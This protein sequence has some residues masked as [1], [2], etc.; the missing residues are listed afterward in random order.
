M[1][2]A[3]AGLLKNALELSKSIYLEEEGNESYGKFV[4]WF[5][6]FGIFMM[7]LY[8]NWYGFYVM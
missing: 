3:M 5:G 6:Y 2:V 4:A 8:L 1:I 7:N